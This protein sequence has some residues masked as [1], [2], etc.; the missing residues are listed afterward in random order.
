MSRRNLFIVSFAL[1]AVFATWYGLATVDVPDVSFNEAAAITDS[2]V[3]V[4]VSGLVASGDVGD[5]NGALTFSM[6]D[7]QGS[8][9]RVQYEGQDPVTGDDVRTAFTEK[10]GVSVSG[11]SHGEYFH[12]TG[13]TIH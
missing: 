1:I 5:D 9:L 13:M 12:A 6:R 3:K 4:I 2:K 7:G 8:V 11:H 10:R